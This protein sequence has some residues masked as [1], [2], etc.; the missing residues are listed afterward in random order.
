MNLTAHG[1]VFEWYRGGDLDHCER[2]NRWTPGKLQRRLEARP[3]TWPCC[4]AC[5]PILAE[6]VAREPA[7]FFE[8]G[9]GH[10]PGTVG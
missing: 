7:P 8:D 4:K 10:E 1:I 3:T 9:V 5:A 6:L 2:C